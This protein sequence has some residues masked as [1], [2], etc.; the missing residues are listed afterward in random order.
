MTQWLLLALAAS[1]SADLVFVRAPGAEAC[2]RVALEN[3]VATRLGYSPFVAVAPLKLRLEVAGH[4]TLTARLTVL[5]EGAAPATRTLTG[6][7]DCQQLIEALGLA[8][9][10]V[11]D[12]LLLTR[13]PP[14]AAKPAA[15]QPTPA[16]TE[17]EVIAP[18]PVREVRT[19]A[20]PEP[21]APPAM[22]QGGLVWA[23]FA[24]DLGATPGL[25]SGTLGF[26][27]RL[28]WFRVGLGGVVHLPAEFS[29]GSQA[30]AQTWGVEGLAQACGAWRWVGACLDLRAGGRHHRAVGLTNSTDGWSPLVSLGPR[31]WVRWSFDETARAAL[32]L[33]VGVTVPVVRTSMVVSSDVVWTQPVAGFMVGL[34]G[35]VR[36]W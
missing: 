4:G 8:L 26:Q 16:P 10:V 29:L 19:A 30:S 6:P 2:E 17:P 3:A 7:A 5:R 12:P 34:G 31:A 27:W 32:R 28:N 21:P 1:P 14:P 20:V 13:P 11:I 33:D 36:L 25:W 9:A 22:T 35:E 15:E 24:L 23:S 18:R